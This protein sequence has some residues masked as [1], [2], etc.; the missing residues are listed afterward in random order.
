MHNLMK[1][2]ENII[3]M[4]LKHLEMSYINE[5]ISNIN[6]QV[7]FEDILINYN[8]QSHFKNIFAKNV[9]SADEHLNSLLRTTWVPPVQRLKN[10]DCD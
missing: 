1:S 8:K 3:K 9:P 10:Q 4:S 2:C 6:D 7:Q 5:I